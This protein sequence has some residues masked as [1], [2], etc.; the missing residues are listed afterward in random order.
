MISISPP[1][2]NILEFGLVN[3]LPILLFPFKV[4]EILF[5]NSTSRFVHYIQDLPSL[6]D[7]L[8]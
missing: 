5:M 2:S 7:R 3:I 1:T 8:F 6:R 4:Q